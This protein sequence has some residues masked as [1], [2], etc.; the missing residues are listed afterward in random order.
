MILYRTIVSLYIVFPLLLTS[1]NGWRQS[2]V[3]LHKRIYFNYQSSTIQCSW[4]NIFKKKFLLREW[5]LVVT[6]LLRL[7]YF[8]L[9]SSRRKENILLE[10]R[11]TAEQPIPTAML[12][13]RGIIIYYFIYG[14]K[15][16][17]EIF[18]KEI[19]CTLCQGSVWQHECWWRRKEDALWEYPGPGCSWWVDTGEYSNTNF[20]FLKLF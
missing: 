2:K 16:F 17:Y 3:L 6:R 15:T 1:C 19:F 13:W 11:A 14:K 12:R 7:N 18:L 10:K 4:Y 8:F 5:D 9:S 20:Y